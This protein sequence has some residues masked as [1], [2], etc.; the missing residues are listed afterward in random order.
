LP[1]VHMVFPLTT[2]LQLLSPFLSLAFSIFYPMSMGLHILQIGG[3]F[4]GW[5]LHLFMLQSSEVQMVVPALFGT[6]YLL[7]SLGA[8][9]SKKLFYVLTLIVLIFSLKLFMGFWI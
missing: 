8:F 4:D 2:P 7:L 6:S 9:Y 5:L 3:L 1:V